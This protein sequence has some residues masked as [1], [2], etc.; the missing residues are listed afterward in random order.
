MQ[1][2]STYTR[3]FTNFIFIILSEYLTYVVILLL[4]VL[5]IPI[6]WYTCIVYLKG[7]IYHIEAYDSDF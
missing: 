5:G 7:F 3:G 2:L 6:K 4:N 1:K